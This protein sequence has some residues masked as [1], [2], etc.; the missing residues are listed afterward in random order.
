LT[1]TM[2]ALLGFGDRSRDRLVLR[3]ERLGRIDDEDGDIRP[4]HRAGGTQDAVLLD[5]A[6]DPTRAPDPGRVNQHHPVPRPGDFGVDRVPRRARDR[7]DDLPRLAEQGVEQGRLPDVGPAHDRD[8]RHLLTL[9]FRG[10]RQM[11]DDRIQQVAHTDAVQRRDG[12]G[13]AQSQLVE[14]DRGILDRARLGLI[15]GQEDR[16]LGAPDEVGHLVVSGG[17]PGLPVD[18]EDDDVGLFDGQF[19]LLLG[20][21]R[22]L[23][24]RGPLDLLLAQEPAGIHDVERDPAPV[25]LGIDPVPCRP[26][27]ILDDGAALPDQAVEKSRL[28]GVRPADN[29]H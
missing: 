15:Y 3:R 8:A 6:L 29:R 28:T 11:G 14:L 26:G 19:R 27:E 12:V 10:L 4:L 16:P 20:R 13:I 24:R 21:L 18:H 22:D 2:I 5:P 7:R 1:A 9:S 17:D 25:R 23:G